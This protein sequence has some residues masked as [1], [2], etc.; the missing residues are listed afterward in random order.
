MA[1]I[2]AVRGRAGTS[3]QRAATL[4]TGIWPVATIPV[5]AALG[6]LPHFLA[7]AVW[8]VCWVVAGVALL[9]GSSP[10]S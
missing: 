6:D 5:G 3:L 1:G 9:T 10:R 8:G 7:I 4:L 2:A